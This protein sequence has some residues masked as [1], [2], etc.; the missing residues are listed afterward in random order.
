MLAVLAVLVLILAI[1]AAWYA[2]NRK[3]L[4]E[5]PT[6]T[7]DKMPH[8]VFSIYGS[9][10]PMGVA[11]SPAGDR[12]YVTESDGSRLVKIYDRS[13]KK[14]GQ[15][16][17]PK[18]STVA[19]RVP[20]YVA[21]DP[22]SSDVYVSDRPSQSILVYNR[23]GGFRRTFKP[24]GNLGGGY[25]P[26]GLAFDKPGNLYVTDVSAKIHR[27]L[28]FARD[29]K[30]MRTLDSTAK[31]AFPNGIALDARGTA[32]ISDSNNGRLVTWDTAGKMVATINRGVGAGDLGLPRG[33]AIDNSNRLYVVDTSAHM[34]KVY[35]IATS[36]APSAKYTG[37]FG[38]EGQLD[39]KFEFPN[40][41]AT[42]TRS[43]IYVTDRENNRVQ[44]W[45]Y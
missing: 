29:G 21:I 33:T 35:R 13:G 18:G 38:D 34:V 19:S 20:V 45:S 41:V 28:V 1:L 43:R 31:L 16:T 6:F 9:E 2:M 26:L 3:P 5:L 14:V 36:K 32:Y 17:P 44:V 37:S 30:L 39:G 10:R 24:V 40:G 7:N 27:V 8:Y 15:L 25:S 11:V 42:D 23:D 12:V 22:I 4:T